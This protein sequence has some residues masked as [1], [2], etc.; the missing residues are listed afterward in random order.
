[1]RAWQVHGK[2]EPIDVLEQVEVPT[3]PPGPGQLQVRVTAAARC[4][5]CLIR[6]RTT[7]SG[8]L[9]RGALRPVQVLFIAT[10]NLLDPIPAALRDRMEI[11]QLPGYAQQEKIEIGKRFLIPKQLE[12][13]A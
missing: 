9:P 7:R 10:A 11:V 12:T 1:M 13:T 6:S 2:G 5:R 4:S 8:Q 3:P